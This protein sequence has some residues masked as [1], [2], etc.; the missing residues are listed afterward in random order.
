MLTRMD[1]AGEHRA[2]KN[3][4]YVVVEGF[5]C[6]PLGHTGIALGVGR[7]RLDL[8]AQNAATG[9]DCLDRHN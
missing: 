1:G 3:C 4:E 7:G 6:Q 9:I 8:A 2:K 5:L